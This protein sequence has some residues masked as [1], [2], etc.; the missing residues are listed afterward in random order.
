M[1]NVGRAPTA[2]GAP[3]ML[4]YDTRLDNC[5]DVDSGGTHGYRVGKESD[6]RNQQDA[7]AK[8]MACP[9]FGPARS[10]GSTLKIST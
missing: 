10:A 9:R 4:I 1:G 3:H 8:G 6:T 2:E 5:I 7:M